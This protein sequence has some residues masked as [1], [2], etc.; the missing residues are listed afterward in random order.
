MKT[1]PEVSEVDPC[2]NIS[3]QSQKQTAWVR[4]FFSNNI[5]HPIIKSRV[6]PENSGKIF[7]RTK[8]IPQSQDYFLKIS[9]TSYLEINIKISPLIFV[10]SGTPFSSFLLLWPFLNLLGFGLIQFKWIGLLWYRIFGIFQL[11]F[12]FW[13]GSVWSGL[14]LF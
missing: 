11:Y 5:C 12:W 14:V 8:L 10:S 7:L 9:A 2:I 13:F 3:Y 4:K 1:R 6:Y